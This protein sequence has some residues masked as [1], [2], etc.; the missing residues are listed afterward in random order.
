MSAEIPIIR[1]IWHL[2]STCR[3]GIL[4]FAKR[5]NTQPPLSSEEDNKHTKPVFCAGQLFHNRCLAQK[6]PPCY[7][8]YIP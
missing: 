4:I 6:T 7:N 8:G 1:E 2:Q 5:I 3:G